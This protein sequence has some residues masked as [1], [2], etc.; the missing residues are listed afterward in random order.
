MID[1]LSEKA[2]NITKRAK[3]PEGF[4]FGRKYANL[5]QFGPWW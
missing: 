3:N 5:S 4:V 1:F 2:E